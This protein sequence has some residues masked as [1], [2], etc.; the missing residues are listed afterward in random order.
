MLHWHI[1]SAHIIWEIVI[2]DMF[3]MNVEISNMKVTIKIFW[4]EY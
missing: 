3:V 1:P 4:F 2:L